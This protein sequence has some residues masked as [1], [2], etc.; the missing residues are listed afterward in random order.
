MNFL[1]S[2]LLA[3]SILKAMSLNFREQGGTANIRVCIIGAGASGLI[4]AQTLSS[5]SPQ[6]QVTILEK[7]TYVGGIWKYIEKRAPTTTLSST[8]SLNSDSECRQNG[9]TPTSMTN[10]K[11]FTMYK[12]L[13]TNLPKQIMQFNENFPFPPSVPSFPHHEQ[14]QAYLEDFATANNLL[15]HIRFS[16]LVTKVEESDVGSNHSQC[17]NNISQSRKSW[18]VTSWTHGGGEHEEDFDAV[19]VCNGHFNIP[20][21]PHIPG[22]EYVEEMKELGGTFSMHSQDYD[23]PSIFT[24]KRVLLIGSK[25][26]GTDLSREISEHA[27]CVHV[28]DRSFA[29]PSH[30]PSDRKGNIFHHPALTKFDKIINDNDNHNHNDNDNDN[31]NHNGNDDSVKDKFHLVAHFADGFVLK[32]PIDV[33]IWCTGYLYSIPFLPSSNRQDDNDNYAARLHPSGKKIDNLYLQL[34]SIHNPTLCFLGLPFSVVPFPLYFFQTLAVASVLLKLSAL[35][36]KEDQIKWLHEYEKTHSIEKYHYLG[37]MQWKYDRQ[38]L[39]LGAN[40]LTQLESTPLA[41]KYNVERLERYIQY[42]QEIYEDCVSHRPAYPG[43]PD[44]YRSREYVVNANDL[45]WSVSHIQST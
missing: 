39:E 10:E 11:R 36:S 4:S 23:D 8:D 9:D 25:S 32:E 37:D 7:E 41:R 43:A 18:K 30:Q 24:G 14:V 26:S 22:W 13:R 2:L 20:F 34:F 29:G 1:L 21:Q 17:D 28:A 12:S 19:L 44:D 6:F 16:T 38:L 15:E 45:T 5:L 33:I 42:L 27:A 35:P 31:H 3:L 40:A